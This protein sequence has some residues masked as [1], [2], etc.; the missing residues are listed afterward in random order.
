M[1][2]RIF[3]FFA[4]ACVVFLASLSL[5]EQSDISPLL[6]GALRGLAF[7]CGLGVRTVLKARSDSNNRV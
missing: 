2:Q 1:G 4:C 6:R 7:G 3:L 5:A